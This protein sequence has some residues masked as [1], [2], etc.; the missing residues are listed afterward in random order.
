MDVC[1]CS[2]TRDANVSSIVCLWCVCACADKLWVGQ[3]MHLKRLDI[4]GR[5]RCAIKRKY[6]S[7]L[8]VEL[9]EQGAD[10]EQYKGVWKFGGHSHDPRTGEELRIGRVGRKIS[11]IQRTLEHMQQW[12][13]QRGMSPK[14]QKETTQVDARRAFRSF[15]IA[16]DLDAVFGVQANPVRLN[17][18]P[19]EDEEAASEEA[20]A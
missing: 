7:H 15:G 3:G 13:T 17:L 14:P 5:G 6:R 19:K 1:G 20:Q 8:Y 12:R 18:K 2:L 4:K 16:T 10:P 9:R 11:T